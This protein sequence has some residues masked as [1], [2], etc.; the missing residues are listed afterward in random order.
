MLEITRT[1]KSAEKFLTMD[2]RDTLSNVRKDYIQNL[3]FVLLSLWCLFP[4]GNIP[5]FL[6][7]W[8]AEQK[9]KISISITDNGTVVANS[10]VWQAF[11]KQ[12]SFFFLLGILTLCVTALYLMFFSHDGQYLKKM[13][14]R[15]PW[16]FCLLFM[17]CWAVL[18]TFLSE[19]PLDRFVGDSYRNDGLSSYFI[20]ASV[21]IC[22]FLLQSQKLRL[23]FL[24]LFTMVVNFCALVMFAQVWKLS[25]ITEIIG[26]NGASSVFRH[27][28]HF[29][30][31]LCMSL[32]TLAGL[33]FYETNLKW[34]I[35]ALL[36]FILQTYALL[37]NDTLGAYLAVLF[38]LP[39]LYLFYRKSGRKFYALLFAPL[40]L[41][42]LISLFHFLA[43][44]PNPT[45]KPYL[46]NFTVLSGDISRLAKGTDTAGH[47]G[48]NRIYLWRK[49]VEQIQRY[50]IL[51]VGPDGPC[52]QDSD[53]TVIDRTHNEFLQHA[54]LLGIPALL[55]YLGA[56]V[57]L[58]RR[59]WLYLPKLDETILIPAGAVVGYLFSSFFGVTMFYTV[60][61]FFM[62]LGM[63]ATRETEIF[64]S[65][66][67]QADRKEEL[68]DQQATDQSEMNRQETD[69]Q[70]TTQQ[71]T[72]QPNPDQKA[73]NSFSRLKFRLVKA[74]FF[75]LAVSIILM[76]MAA[77]FLAEKLEYERERADIARMRLALHQAQIILKE[78]LQET[79]IEEIVFWFDPESGDLLPEAYPV[80]Y[81]FGTSRDS[82]HY[83]PDDLK[84]MG[85]ETYDTNKDYRNSILRVQIAP[86]SEEIVVE[87]IKVES[88]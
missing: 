1:S 62:L 2:L 29:G 64:I 43:L 35:C 11:Q 24:R 69:Q 80:A 33:F 14:R 13:V 38:V 74:F 21:Y 9:G 88:A 20:Y 54:V 68:P 3:F 86:I 17:L 8:Q 53:A 76:V 83:T 40:I 16:H 81:G 84:N 78:Q 36:S 39:V 77:P 31:M 25:P 6:Y 85:I 55:A 19:S 10:V 34:R 12:V 45:N 15:E 75:A 72:D 79:E 5:I 52:Y 46:L 41:F 60:P 66:Q 47:G 51:G 61:Y 37:L 59:Q 27:W 57:T 50:P 48:S 87:W 26:G 49:T 7:Y 32:L 44:L 70:E 65:D 58:A 56:L 67:K 18:S 71:E 63:T 22:G 82:R 42:L 4:L 73:E 23:F 28:N 30:Y